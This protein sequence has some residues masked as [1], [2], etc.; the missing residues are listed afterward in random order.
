MQTRSGR[1]LD[2]EG[3]EGSSKKRAGPEPRKGPVRK[4]GAAPQTNKSS[5]SSMSRKLTT[6][7]GMPVSKMV[8]GGAAFRDQPASLLADA[9]D[10][11]VNSFFAYNCKTRVL[12]PPAAAPPSATLARPSTSI[13]PCPKSSFCG[14]ARIYPV[15]FA[16]R[17]M[18]DASEIRK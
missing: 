12:P 7:N 5:A 18:I 17:L 2:D 1:R 14:D 3:T 11:G 6:A 8:L 9:L 10:L 16:H 13:L 4:R 15:G